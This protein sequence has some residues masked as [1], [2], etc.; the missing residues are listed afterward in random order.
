MFDKF[1]KFLI[2][3]AH[4]DDNILGCSGTLESPIN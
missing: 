3:A 1:K 2:V 4:P